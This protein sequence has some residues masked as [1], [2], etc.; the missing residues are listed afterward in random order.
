[1]RVEDDEGADLAGD[2][3]QAEDAHRAGR[4]AAADADARA[5]RAAGGGGPL[6]PLGPGLGRARARFRRGQ[7]ERP[8]PRQL[9]PAA[10]RPGAGRRSSSAGSP[11]RP[12][13]RPARS[14]WH[15]EQ[16][17]VD[18]APTTIRLIGRPQR[19]HGSPVRW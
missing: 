4:V 12:S 14:R 13:G 6:R 18:R 2:A 8:L 9:G 15:H 16:K 7:P 5:A 11:R 3:R 1:M 17:W 10:A 19:G